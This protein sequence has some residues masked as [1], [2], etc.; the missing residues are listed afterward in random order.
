MIVTTENIDFL[1]NCFVIQDEVK[2]VV[3]FPSPNY[4]VNHVIACVV[5]AIL[6]IITILLNSITI[7]AYWKSSELKK[8]VSYFLIMV[9]S[10][11]NFGVG[12]VCSSLFTSLLA[13]EL[14]RT[15]K[16]E[17]VFATRKM[18]M[19]LSG[20]SISMLFAINIERFLG[21]VYPML[22]RTK[23]TRKKFL[24]FIFCMWSSWIIMLCASFIKQRAF[25]FFFMANI[26]LLS[27][28]SVYIYGRIF[29]AAR[30]SHRIVR[31]QNV[32]TR[33]DNVSPRNPKELN[34]KRRS[35]QDIKLAKTCFVIV[36]CLFVS[37][38]PTAVTSFL[39]IRAFEY[40]ILRTWDVTFLLMNPSLNSVV[41]FWGNRRL[42]NEAKANL[43]QVFCN[44]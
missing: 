21:I 39:N 12:M 33:D 43:K 23:L 7:I 30:L 11:I 36:V 26:T 14:V 35:L 29:L 15:G 24:I 44:L 17:L 28:V 41:F 40:I 37:L 22:H 6:A 2:M 18:I 34:G 3:D 10:S 32:P 13:S 4:F 25:G 8:K 16:C 19:L 31:S 5:N 38:M 1:K 42:R 27:A 9:Q 20:F